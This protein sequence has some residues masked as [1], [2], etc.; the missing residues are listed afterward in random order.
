M[1]DFEF[2]EEE[3][4]ATVRLL[5]PW[6][7]MIVDDEHIIHTT[8]KLALKGFE[9]EG[10]HL[11]FISCYTAAEAHEVLKR[12]DDIAMILLDVVMENET[13]GLDLARLIREQLKNLNVRIVLRT[14]QPG[15]APEEAAIRDYDINDYKSKSELTR[16]RLVTTLYAALRSYRD[17]MRLEQAMQGLRRTIEAISKVVDS[18]NIYSFASSVLEQ[19]NYLLNI[20]GQG[21]CASRTVAYAAANKNSHLQILAATQEYQSLQLDQNADRLP[22]EVRTAIERAFAEKNEVI[23]DRCFVSYHCSRHGTETVLYMSFA[24][25]ISEAACE[26]LHLFSTNV[27]NTFENLLAREETDSTQRTTIHMI[28][29]AV[30]QRNQFI[31]SHVQRVGEIAALLARAIGLSEQAADDIRMAA[32]LHDIGKVAI[33]DTVLNKPGKLDGPEWDTMKKHA[34]LGRDILAKSPMRILQLAATIAHEHHEHW[35]G[36]GYPRALAGVAIGI[37]ARIVALADVFDALVSRSCYKNE[38]SMQESYAYVAERRGTQFD[39]ELVDL[40][41]S[42]EPQLTAIY[43]KYPDIAV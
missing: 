34:V 27:V 6:T 29:E 40:L 32:P 33:P 26:L 31:S 3:Q 12:R 22:E 43:Q 24:D 9:F 35:D 16:N 30:E 17:L 14:G 13:A 4:E 20:Q 1:D 21:V 7:V 10:R 15:Q 39:P 28:G 18:G 11:E 37:E 42:V 38:W 19:V 8:T 2:A 25:P 5:K 36:T 23:A 41:V